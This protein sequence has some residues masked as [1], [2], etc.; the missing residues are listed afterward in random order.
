MLSDPDPDGPSV[1]VSV[2]ASPVLTDVACVVALSG[3]LA[4]PVVMTVLLMVMTVR[5]ACRFARFV[6]HQLSGCACGLY[7]VCRLRD[8]G[9]SSRGKPTSVDVQSV[10]LNRR[11]SC[12][13][14][15]RG[16]CVYIY[17]YIYIL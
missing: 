16:S 8:A 3:R 10:E 15:R 9:T 5:A 6:K 2:H 14:N 13:L 11:G 17:I 1:R 12:V 7:A 4:A